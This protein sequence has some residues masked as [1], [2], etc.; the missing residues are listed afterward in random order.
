MMR[1]P[2]P[3]DES[4]RLEALAKYRVLDTPP[5][6]VFDHLVSVACSIFQTPVGL[7]S[8]VA[9][10]RTWYKARRG[11]D[12]PDTPRDVS[13]CAH[14]ILSSDVLCIEDALRDERF[15]NFS[16]AGGG[17]V[18]RFYAG[19]P[20]RTSEG[21][22]LGTVC[23]ADFN[24]RPAPPEEQRTA[25]V[26]LA[27][28]AMAS[29]EDRAL[30]DRLRRAEARL[31]RGEKMEAV[32]RLAGGIAHRCNNLLTIITGYSQILQE[33]L[34]PGTPAHAYSEEVFRASQRM[35]MLTSHLLAF[36]R[37]RY[38]ELRPTDLNLLV[39]N[40]DKALRRAAGKEVDLVVNTIPE[41]G[42]V[43]ADSAELEQAL[44]ILVANAREAMPAGGTIRIETDRVA[45]ETEFP[46][47]N[48]DVPS[49]DYVVL[50][51]RDTGEGMTP[52][53]RAHLFEPFFTTKGIGRGTGLATVY[54]IMKQCGGDVAVQ[55]LP[56]QGTAVKL[57]FPRHNGEAAPA[58]RARMRTGTEVILL[59]DE[60]PGVRGALRQILTRHGY[61][62]LVAGSPEEAAHF[63]EHYSGPIH[64]L[65]ASSALSEPDGRD[66]GAR[67]ASA[68]PGL[69][70]LYL[71]DAVDEAIPSL[72]AAGI[73]Y[74]R[75]PFT[76]ENLSAHLREL[77]DENQA[78]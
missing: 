8:F 21:H 9:Q 77:L 53:A 2:V 22:R 69:K 35:A 18:L 30:A 56:G 34:A 59:A 36:S 13:F 60:D 71:C 23:V 73:S 29:L 64:L 1:A 14:A 52:E 42:T 7:L 50:T 38:V 55:S 61:T 25:L 70:V 58:P 40:L 75:K 43:L 63:A 37:R 20:L 66:S 51:V 76:L 27:S 45:I 46:G 68:R 67:I 26:H 65:I 19:A 32:A 28:A 24:P 31:R 74:L 47:G 78:R 49:G 62:V 11:L 33:Q 54:G 44:R 6:P 15:R 41:L 16:S 48:P 72:I 57:F 10:D 4:K 17:P 5:E 3:P 12:I 39:R